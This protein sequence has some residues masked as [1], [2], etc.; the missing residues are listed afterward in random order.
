MMKRFYTRIIER[1]WPLIPV[2]WLFFFFLLPLLIIGTISLTSPQLASTPYAPLAWWEK[3]ALHIRLY[4]KNYTFILNDDLYL[5]SYVQSFIL[6][7]STTIICLI[8]GYP[9]AYAI[10]RVKIKYRFAFV[11]LIILPFWISFLIRVYAWIILLNPAGLINHALMLWGVISSPLQLTDNIFAVGVGMI[12]SYLPF[13]ILPLFNALEKIDPYLLEAA[14]DL[15]CPSSR[16]FWSILV[17]MSYPGILV[18]CAMVFIPVMGEYVIPEFLG[19]TRVLMTGRML[20]NE[21]FYNRDWPLA[22]AFAILTLVILI[23][24]MILFYHIQRTPNS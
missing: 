8:I 20:W 5:W 23:G 3:S 6:A 12:Y 15:G 9:M 4:F 22:C 7:L 24:P 16:A 10:S 1:I 2:L 13:M 11:L 14:Y 18:G 21:F 19:G 17:P